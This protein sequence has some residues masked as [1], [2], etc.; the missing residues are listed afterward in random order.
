MPTSKPTNLRF[1][2]VTF[3]ATVIS[4]LFVFLG[5]PFLRVLRNVYGTR[6]Y[7]GAGAVICASFWFIGLQPLS[8]LLGSIWLT[9]GFYSE[10]EERGRSG[11]WSAAASIALGSSVLIFGSLAWA[12]SQGF[13]MNEI[14]KQGIESMTQQLAARSGSS[15]V[16]LDSAVI[17]QQVPSAV[18]LLLMTSLGF[19]LML[20]RKTGHMTNLR[21]EKI[22]T[23]MKV[24][25]FK[26]PEFLIW[27]TM[28]S[29][30]FSFVKIEP[31]IV[32]VVATNVFNIMMGLYF[33]QGMAV[34]EVSLLSFKVSNFMRFL[35]YF[36][37][38]GQLFFVLSAVGV[39]DY[40]VDFRARMK[41]MRPLGTDQKNGEHV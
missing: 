5:A 22:A 40:W 33:F 16:K 15:A 24:L 31:P 3:L 29:F 14:L 28:L 21:F 25:E 20:D 18:I 13:D 1:L 23:H 30:L 6:K 4:A 35:V 34:L 27:I 12:Q 7:W 10:L 32:G 9:I 36:I 26:N 37:L 38:V 2:T 19:A 39:I 8:F 11:F 41:R 17:I